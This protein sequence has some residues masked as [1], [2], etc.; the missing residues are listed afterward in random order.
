MLLSIEGNF[1]GLLI[2]CSDEIT[3][4]KLEEAHKLILEKHEVM[5]EKV[6]IFEQNHDA[7]LKNILA[8]DTK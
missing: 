6:Q 3:I 2:S 5:L 4:L 7:I 1:F 8:L